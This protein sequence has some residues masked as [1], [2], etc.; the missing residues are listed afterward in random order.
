MRQVMDDRNLA[1]RL[2]EHGASSAAQMT[3]SG[4]IGQLLR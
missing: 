4:A 2:G 1:A 3:W